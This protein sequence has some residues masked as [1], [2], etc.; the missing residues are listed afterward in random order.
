[1]EYNLKKQIVEVLIFASD[2]PI[3]EPKLLTLV[4][5]LDQATLKQ[6]LGDLS[7]E[8]LKQHR[9]FMLSKVAG[10]YQMVTRP[11]F[12]PWIKK[13]FQG[14]SKTR[15]S[16]ASLETLAII[17]FKQ[18]VSR[19]QIEAIR[20][21]QADGV[22]KTL[23]ER[24]LITMAGRSEGVGRPLLYKTTEEF[25][26]HFGINAINDLPKPKE[27]TE[28]VSEP[29][30]LMDSLQSLSIQ[31]GQRDLFTNWDVDE[32]TLESKLTQKEDDATE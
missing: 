6:I 27:I 17:A 14:K 23:L 5:E 25:L 22:I 21:A 19:P 16:Q 4:E 11:E 24:N 26:R 2:F 20:G 29:E 1:M 7:E 18:P 3:P 30:N 12:A 28:L 31:M 9:S 8:Y 32:A 10:G 15:L 13:L